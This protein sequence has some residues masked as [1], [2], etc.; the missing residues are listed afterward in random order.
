MK[1]LT[2]KNLLICLLCAALLAGAVPTASAAAVK[3]AQVKITSVKADK[4]KVKIKWKKAKRA[5]KYQVYV[6]TGKKAFQKVKTTT[7]LSYTYSGRYKT[8]YVVKVRA[9]NGSKKGRFSKTRAVTTPKPKIRSASQAE[10]YARYY[11]R[12]KKG[13]TK[14]LIFEYDHMD[15][16]RYLVHIYYMMPD[17]TATVAWWSIAKNGVVYD[18]LLGGRVS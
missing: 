8:R 16:G 5:K 18:W 10:A 1:L 6:K 11:Y 15:G 17:H 7:K 13:S 9:V 12:L 14:N 2:R 3:P 4:H